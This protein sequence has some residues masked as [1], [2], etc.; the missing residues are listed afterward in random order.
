MQR[1]LLSIGLICCLATQSIAAAETKCLHS[2]NQTLMKSLSRLGVNISTQVMTD[3][4]K[5][6][7]SGNC[8]LEAWPRDT[9]AVSELVH[10]AYQHNLPMRILG[11]GHS[12]NGSTLP[13]ASEILIRTDYLN[14]IKFEKQGEVT[15]GAGIPM[16]SI[17]KYVQ[18]NSDF[19]LPVLNAAGIGPT[20][21][22]YISAGGISY[23]SVK[24]GGFWNHVR[25]IT[26]VVSNGDIKHIN[27]DDPIFPWMFGSM[28]QFGVITEAK[29]ILIPKTDA[30]NPHYP[31][32]KQ[33]KI[34]Y[35]HRNYFAADHQPVYW[36]NLF[37]NR[38]QML[39][40]KE[41]LKN[42]EANY[43]DVLR[44]IPIY[45]WVISQNRFV[46]PLLYPVNEDFYATGVWGTPGPAFSKQ[47]LDNMEKEFS[48]LVIKNH[49]HRYLQAELFDQPVNYANYYGNKTYQ[50]FRE[51]KLKLDPKFLFNPKTIF[52]K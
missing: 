20:L 48:E 30:A 43:P 14:T 46:P 49:Y 8:Y 47:K 24:R 9:K 27:S 6:K 36:F 7:R 16:D 10:F 37:V 52:D 33:E 15:A 34:T 3:Y 25:E 17:N 50:S 35:Q 29:L 40:A 22:G 38:E 41:A 13:Q 28:G 5:I 11:N 1:T 21:G 45:E 4:A 12:Q 19:E 31:L 39:G 26:I 44:Y 32:N 2:I 18:A 51:I 42:F 23:T